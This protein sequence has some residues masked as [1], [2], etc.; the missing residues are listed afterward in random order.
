[1]L[2]GQ[3]K[4][5]YQREYMR[6]YRQS[7]RPML[8]PDVRPTLL[9]PVKTHKDLIKDLQTKIDTIRPLEYTKPELCQQC[10]AL[11]RHTIATQQT[12]I[13]TDIGVKIVWLCDRCDSRV[14]VY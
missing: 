10:K 8:D 5:D 12:E 2:K 6:K 11:G 1:M 4:K 3:A 9:D 14:R 7:V 13:I